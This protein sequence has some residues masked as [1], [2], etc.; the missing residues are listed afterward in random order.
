MRIQLHASLFTKEPSIIMPSENLDMDA[1]TEARRSAIAES[2]HPISVEELTELGEGLFPNVDHPWRE[3]FFSFLKENAGATFHH[4]TTNDRL[5][6]IYCEAVDKGMWFL[7]GS[8]MG[9]I[10]EKG[11]K[12]L[13]EI[14][15]R[16]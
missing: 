6:L 7:P 14:V 8:G 3:K 9:P 4:A 2:I 11:R 15:Q 1:V 10:Q 16:K 12:I 5:H 13:K